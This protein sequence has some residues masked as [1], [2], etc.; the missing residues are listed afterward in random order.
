MKKTLKTL[1]IIM[2]VIITIFSVSI[3]ALA[4][5]DV[6][7]NENV[8]IASERV[9]EI[10]S[11]REKNSKTFCLQTVL[12]NTLVMLKTFIMKMKTASSKLL[13]TQ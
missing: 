13:T 1:F 7:R 12:I 3:V 10:E 9:K 5:D 6:S 8:I 2:L 11:L 4:T